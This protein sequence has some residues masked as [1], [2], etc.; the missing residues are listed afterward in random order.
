MTTGYVN[1]KYIDIDSPT[2][3]AT[4]IGFLRGYGVYEGITSYNSVPYHLKEH[5]ER[6][7]KSAGFLNIKVPVSLDELDSIL[8]ELIAKN[9][10]TRTDFRLILTGGASIEGIGFESMTPTIAIIPQNHHSLSSEA[11][12]KGVSIILDDFQREA[13]GYKTLNYINAVRL[14]EKRK[15][16]GAA[17][18]IYHHVGK[19][20]EASTSNVF[21]VKN[22]IVITPKENILEGITRKVVMELAKELG[23]TVE[24]RA[25][26]MDEF[27]F[28]D[29]VF[30]TASF[31]EIVPVVKADEN[32]VGGGHP[33]P[34]TKAFMDAFLKHTQ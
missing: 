12:E 25:V 13:A 17:E 4:D 24:E 34:V 21:I 18:I 32:T 11:Y 7:L 26:S 33:G 29:E 30:M 9:N 22:N 23:Y 14:Q 20:L 10:F 31:K 28:A 5:Y 15:Q 2:I 6:L 16:A 19:L 27:S 3:L 1:G 8:R